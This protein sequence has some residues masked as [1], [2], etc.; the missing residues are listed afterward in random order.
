MQTAS[1]P[2]AQKR[3]RTRMRYSNRF[4]VLM[5]YLVCFAI[6][7][8]W[9]LGCLGFVY[10]YQLKNSA[11]AVMETLLGIFPFLQPWLGPLTEA[12]AAPE[13][14]L[15]TAEAWNQMQQAR[16][17]QW[18][19]LLLVV[20]GAAWLLTLLCQLV[21]RFGYTKALQS[22]KTVNRAVV[23]YRVMLLVIL[24][25]N[26]AISAGL[27]LVGVQFING[28]GIWD[29]VTYFVPCGLNLIAAMCCFRLAAPPA[30]SGKKAF[31]KRL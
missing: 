12:A 21:W 18:I 20:F 13:G 17:T 23:H 26:L 16:E 14:S 11:P 5:C 25:I 6:P 3:K 30:I 10:P 8:L 28:R 19:L 7:P 24:L 31:F 27:W 29:Y 9:L 15:L 4:K 1:V 22:A 2:V